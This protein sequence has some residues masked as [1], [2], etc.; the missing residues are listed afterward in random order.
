MDDKDI[1]YS[2][3]IL[4]KKKIQPIEV[5][6]QVGEQWRVQINVRGLRFNKKLIGKGQVILVSE[7][8]LA[9]LRQFMKSSFGGVK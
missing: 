1:Q 9:E 5:I 3:K 7:E 2:K 8:N 6:E 4:K